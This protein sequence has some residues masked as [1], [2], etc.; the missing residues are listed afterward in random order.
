MTTPS[1]DIPPLGP[2]GRVEVD[3]VRKFRTREANQAVLSCGSAG[4]DLEFRESV[5][6]T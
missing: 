5:N 2:G 3:S 1:Q 4:R 6:D